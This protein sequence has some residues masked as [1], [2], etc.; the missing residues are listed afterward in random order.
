M[1]KLMQGFKTSEKRSF[2]NREF[3]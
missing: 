2:F 1:K 3:N